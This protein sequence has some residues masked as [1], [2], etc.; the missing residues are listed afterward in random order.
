KRAIKQSGLSREQ[1]VDAI[2]EYFGWSTEAI[3][4]N[5]RKPLS[6]H[7]FN[8]YLS[9]PTQYPIPSFYIYAIQHVTGSL[10][11]CISFTA[12][13]DAKVISGDE[14]RQMTI[15]KLDETILEMQRLKKELRMGAR[16]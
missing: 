8:H 6:I 3:G 10:E 4:K 13:E 15:G 1:V 16:K 5:A 7:I 14:V 9:K 12:A 11:P 2:N